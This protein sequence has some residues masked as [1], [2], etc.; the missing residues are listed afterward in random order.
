[1]SRPSRLAKTNAL[2]SIEQRP[3]DELPDSPLPM[4]ER[5]INSGRGLLLLSNNKSSISPVV[6]SLGRGLLG[7]DRNARICPQPGGDQPLSAI[8]SC[9]PS[10]SSAE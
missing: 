1:M 6:Q 4:R 2:A 8:V 5:I 7:R 10:V 3:E 9:N